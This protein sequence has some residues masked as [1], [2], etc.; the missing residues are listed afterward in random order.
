M[1]SRLNSNPMTKIRIDRFLE[2]F[3]LRLR[4]S[5]F[6][7]LSTSAVL[8]QAA[9]RRVGA[10]E[11][12]AGAVFLDVGAHVGETALALASAFPGAT[13]HAFEPIT[14]IYQQLT[15]NCR[16]FPGIIC[17]HL[18]LGNETAER[19]IALISGDVACTENQVS[20]TADARTPD[21]L[22]D[23]I[24]INRLDDFCQSHRI[25]KIALLKTDTEGFELEVFKGALGTL[26]QSLVQSILVE[27]T[28]WKNNPQ[29]VLYD[30]VCALL[31]PLGFELGGFYDHGY[32][33]DTG[34]MWYTN[35]FFTLK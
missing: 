32:K 13:I 31:Q 11:D 18:A 19:R 3:G 23:T 22:C 15:Q 30:D 17:H 4:K 14:A 34:R 21:A 35:A 12:G 25:G 6:F 9:L 2:R 8:H 26:R 24:K 33:Q 27:V 7:P 29:H 5:A 16:R 1:S 10:G 20:R 28:F